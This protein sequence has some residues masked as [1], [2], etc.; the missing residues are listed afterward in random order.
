MVPKTKQPQKRA[1][2]FIGM[3]A[4]IRNADTIQNYLH[5]IAKEVNQDCDER[6]QMQARRQTTRPGS[7][8]CKQIAE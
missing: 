1:A 6:A 8:Q 3:R 7:F 4:A 5:P 2:V